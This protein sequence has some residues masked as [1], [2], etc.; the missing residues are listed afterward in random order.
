MP[1]NDRLHHRNPVF[2][3]FFERESPTQVAQWHDPIRTLCENIETNQSIQPVWRRP[4]SGG[5]TFF[6][7]EFIFI[8][9]DLN[10]EL[11]RLWPPGLRCLRAPCA[12]WCRCVP[13]R[14]GFC[15]TPGGCC[16]W[17]LGRDRH[18]AASRGSRSPPRM[19]VASDPSEACSLSGW[20]QEKVRREKGE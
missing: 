18:P 13:P 9:L 14:T 8:H 4:F 1:T 20:G 6:I 10:W 16:I 7:Y 2:V 17:W 12:G 3:Y 5:E 15:G 11:T 19:L